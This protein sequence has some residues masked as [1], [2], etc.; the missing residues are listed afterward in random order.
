[1]RRS[2]FLKLIPAAVLV[3]TIIQATSEPGV[4]VDCPVILTVTCDHGEIHAHQTGAAMIEIQVERV[5]T[6]DHEMLYVNGEL[7]FDVLGRLEDY[8]LQY[9]TILKA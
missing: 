3:P 2:D 6:E 4:E 7:A 5:T 9:T 1:M 8:T